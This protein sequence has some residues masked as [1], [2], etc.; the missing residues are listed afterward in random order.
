[1]NRE[2]ERRSREVLSVL[3]ILVETDRRVVFLGGSAIQAT[4][5]QPRRLSIDLDISYQGAPEKLIER[6]RN[7]GYHVQRR[8]SSSPLFAFYSVTRDNVKVKLDVSHFR[9]AETG[10]ISIAGIRVLVPSQSYFLASKLSSLASGTVGRLD[11]E[12]LQII[13][14][15]FDIHC[16]LDSRPGLGTMRSE[17]RQILSDQNALRKTAYTEAQCKAD[18]L[19]HLLRCMGVSPTNAYFISPNTFRSFEEMLFAG[20]LAL[21]GFI[22]M[23]ARALLL[24]A[25]MD[26]G[27]Y[28]L[29]KE[30][31]S[32]AADL[33]SLDDAEKGLSAQGVL[34]AGSLRTL[35]K[36]A[37]QALMYLRYWSLS[38]L[39]R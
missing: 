3:S 14:D 13:K 29:E 23:A 35:K 25:S 10:T 12:P 38:R 16:L 7:V 34:D 22:T 21:K 17:W 31:L 32:R 5:R 19:A 39:S 26:D 30:A 1:M 2:F 4:L 24:L 8:Q 37:P 9:I 28:S 6:L 18:T 27:F 15:I 20:K 33:G 11:V 36:I